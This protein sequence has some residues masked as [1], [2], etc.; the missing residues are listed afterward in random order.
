MHVRWFD[1]QESMSSAEMS[2]N[3]KHLC[4]CV[5]QQQPGG[6]SIA[7]D[8]EGTHIFWKTE[9]NFTNLHCIFVDY[10]KL[11]ELM[12]EMAKLKTE[13]HELLKQNVVRTK[14]DENLRISR[15]YILLLL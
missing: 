7:A 15:F 1:L 5:D 2:N 3:N 9:N 6:S 8:S 10:K 12:Q 14:F 13:K 4:Y 11:E